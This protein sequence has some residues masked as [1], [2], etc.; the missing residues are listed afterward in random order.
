MS[1][2]NL[3]KSVLGSRDSV[4]GIACRENSRPDR[5]HVIRLILL[6]SVM[7]AR[8]TLTQ[9]VQVRVLV[10]QLN[11]RLVQFGVDVT[12]SR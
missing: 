3:K 7:V 4:P 12:L 8:L 6:R 2:W 9:L 1:H 10:G 11:D 5:V